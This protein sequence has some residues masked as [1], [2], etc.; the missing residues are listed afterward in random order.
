M[1]V[2]L[3]TNVL[4]YAYDPADPRKQ[5]AALSLL[6]R[7]G[8]S[9]LTISAQVVSEFYNAVQR[10]PEPLDEREATLASRSLLGLR[11]IA[12]DRDVVDRALEIRARWQPSY[13]D[14]LILAAAERAGAS[15][16]Y[17][18]DLQHGQTIAGVEIVDPFADLSA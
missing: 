10:L 4:V 2:F 12:V 17:T 3:D 11:V 7:H 1:T 13:W 5:D 14:S 9:D 15:V 16:L 8:H 6:T 18:E